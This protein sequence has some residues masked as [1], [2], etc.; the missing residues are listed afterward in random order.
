[1]WLLSTA[2]AELRYFPAPE[3]IPKGYAI[4]SHVWGE[5]EQTFQDIQALR[6]RCAES[7]DSPRDLASTKI[8][9]FCV[10]AERDGYNWG[11]VD[12]CCIDKTSSSEL[13][14][15][16][17]SMYRY[18]TLA[19]V[20]YAYLKDVPTD[21]ATDGNY[22]AFR[23]SVWHRR[24]WTLQELIAPRLVVLL[25]Q[26]WEVIGAKADLALLLEEVTNVPTDVL[27]LEA[28]PSDYCIAAR[29]AWAAKRETTRPEDEAYCLMG[30]FGIF[31]PALYGEGRNAFRRLQEE[32]MKTSEDSSIFA[33]GDFLH[34]AIDIVENVRPEYRH[35]VQLVAS[36]LFAP[37]PSSFVVGHRIKP[38]NE[39]GDQPTTRY[40]LPR[41][42]A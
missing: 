31:M 16:I 41:V 7:G 2:R 13:T 33:W 29:M 24:G 32:I 40:G 21:D 25:S 5:D 15:A 18:Y 10:L 6:A 28:S 11:W 17:N 8:R 27:R 14:E 26:T 1:M 3:T 12:T 20:C 39:V 42:S 38:K 30:I 4:L 19:E 37:A 35:I 36:G 22:S 9:N 23:K 34:D